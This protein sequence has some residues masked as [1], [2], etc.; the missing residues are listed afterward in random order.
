VPQSPGTSR[1]RFGDA[2]VEVVSDYE[3]L[4]AELE[5]VYGDCGSL[6]IEG[7]ACNLRCTAT[8]LHG[9]SLLSMSF[10]GAPAR[11]PVEV[12][13][14]PYRFLRHQ[15][16][17][18]VSSPVP[19]WRLL[20]NADAGGHLL[21]AGEARMAL[22]NLDQAPPEFILDC[23]VGVAQSAQS[24]VMFLHAASVGVTG[25]G[26]LILAPTKGG[27]STTALA[28]ALR[29]H[30][31]L[32]DD[33]AAV[34]LASCELLPFPKSAGLRDG[35][36]ARMLEERLQACRHIHAPGRHGIPRTAVRVSDLFPSST[37]GPLPLRFAFVLDGLKDAASVRP[38]HAGLGELKR[39]RGLVVMDTMSS[40]GMSAGR[41]LMQLLKVTNLLSGLHCHLVELGSPEET[42]RLIET[43][44]R[45]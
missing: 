35:P 18:E 45:T 20:V 19:G 38:F 39:L 33:V 6:D 41:D 36:L 22:V 34:R 28:L 16:Y 5:A 24:N 43:T 40:W 3:P 13:L 8:L 29:G 37:D 14:G 1:F 11:H 30:S 31:F 44:M 25:S 12:A 7:A 42:A 17:L 4:L 2:V 32:G 27:K 26:A 23:I 9:S 21:I 10:E 15:Q